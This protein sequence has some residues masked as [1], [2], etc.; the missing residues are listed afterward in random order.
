MIV[1]AAS[2]Q[3]AVLQILRGQGGGYIVFL[4]L[5]REIPTYPTTGKDAVDCWYTLCCDRRDEQSAYNTYHITWNHRGNGI[6]SLSV[7]PST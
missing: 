6:H 4:R 7:V 3:V 2:T 1:V 5:R